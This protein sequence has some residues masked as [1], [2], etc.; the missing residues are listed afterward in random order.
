V[1]EA[2]RG[3]HFFCAVALSAPDGKRVFRAEGRVEGRIALQARGEGGFGYDPL[4]LPAET[5]GRTL[6]ELAAEEK[7]K[8]SHRGRALARLQPLL[9]RL[10][11]EGAL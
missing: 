10:A 7:N 2:R 9:Q 11:D 3:A 5:P 8:I 6:A 4:F 1:P